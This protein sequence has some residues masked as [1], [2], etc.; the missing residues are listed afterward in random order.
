MNNLSLILL[1]HNEA[2]ELKS[3]KKWIG[4]ITSINEIIVVDD[5]STDDTLIQAKKLESITCSVKVFT[6][7]LN[8]NFSAQRQFAISKTSNNLILWLDPDETPT[9]KL[10]G[11][12]ND[13][14]NCQYKSIAFKR[15][16]TF[17]NQ[18]L[19]HGENYANN[20]IRLF[21]KRSGKMVG[22]VH[23]R[24]QTS[25][26][27]YYSNLEI[28]HNPHHDLS[29]FF[30]KIN[31]YSEVRSRELFANKV[32]VGLFEIIF[33]PIAKFIYVYF[34]LLGFLDGTPGIIMALG[35][36]FHSFLVRGKLWCLYN[37]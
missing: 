9:S 19:H 24:W 26:E 35:M 31:F 33:Y 10:I 30:S 21:D 37:P 2:G 20:F 13:I 25:G 34:I 15:L 32:T 27:V 16:D 11:F 18:E 14:D 12:L 22:L 4:Q 5:N 1:T 28:R 3:W 36:S 29:D 8:N 23:E 7:S 6:R 17:L